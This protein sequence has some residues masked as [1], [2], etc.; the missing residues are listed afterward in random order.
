MLVGL[1]GGRGEGSE[2]MAAYTLLPSLAFHCHLASTLLQEQ[3]T[4][5]SVWSGQK[6]P[7]LQL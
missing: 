4:S 3:K 5:I 1:H 7:A 6:L 2:E